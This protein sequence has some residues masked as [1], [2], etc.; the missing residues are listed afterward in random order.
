MGNVLH[1]TVSPAGDKIVSAS[2][3]GTVRVWNAYVPAELPIILQHSAAVQRCAVSPKGDIL[4]SIVKNQI[5]LWRMS[6]G[7]CLTTFY[8]YH[9]FSDCMFHPDGE[10]LLAAAENGLYFLRVVQ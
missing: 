5:K 2:E 1:C 3:D 4:A 7:A 6:S 9:I 10:H 8:A